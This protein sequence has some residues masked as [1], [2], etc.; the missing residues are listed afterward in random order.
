MVCFWS[1]I[2]V[3]QADILCLSGKFLIVIHFSS[4]SLIKSRDAR[5]PC[6]ASK[7]ELFCIN[8][9]RL[10]SVKGFHKDSIIVVNDRDVNMPLETKFYLSQITIYINPFHATCLFPYLLK[11]SGNLSF[12]DV[13]RGYIKRPVT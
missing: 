13:F 3:N 8:N 6:Q 2:R 1:E 10:K 7:M 11:T 5:G 9:E 12:S 4:Q